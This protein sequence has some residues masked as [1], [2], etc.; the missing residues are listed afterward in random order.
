MENKI[1]KICHNLKKII[2]NAVVGIILYFIIMS[3]I[4]VWFFG[5]MLVFIKI[6][7]DEPI[8]PDN[9]AFDMILIFVIVFLPY[10]IY[11][12]FQEKIKETFNKIEDFIENCINA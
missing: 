12:P 11:I 2:K 9:Y 8:N 10:F 3:F 6:C 5:P 7:G 1:Y 4:V